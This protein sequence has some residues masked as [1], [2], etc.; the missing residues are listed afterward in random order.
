MSDTDTKAAAGSLYGSQ[1]ASQLA[2]G[3]AVAA[4]A[5]VSPEAFWT[6]F[7]ANLGGQMQACC[8]H[9]T[10]LDILDVVRAGMVRANESR[11][12]STH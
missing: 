3:I 7:F 1:F 5:D 11:S 10:A 2:P 9:T 12:R 6:L 4:R 8:G